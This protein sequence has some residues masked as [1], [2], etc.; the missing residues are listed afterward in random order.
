MDK[1]ICSEYM[2]MLVRLKSML[3]PPSTLFN[4]KNNLSIELKMLAIAKCYDDISLVKSLNVR[5]VNSQKDIER[6]EQEIYNTLF[7]DN[8][9]ST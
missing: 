3:L 9:F 7:A 6:E 5:I 4:K 2:R 8:N 1:K